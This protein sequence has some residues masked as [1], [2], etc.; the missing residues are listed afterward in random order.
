MFKTTRRSA[1]ALAAIAALAL[2]L[3]AAAKTTL[4][5]AHS[6]AKDHPVDKAMENFAALVKERS[7]GEVEVRVFAAG[8]LG[9]QREL[10]EQL[11]SGAL[12]FAHTNAAPLAAFEPT[13]GIF[14]LPYLFRDDAH[15]F[16]VTDGEIGRE[17]LDSAAA[18]GLV[19]LS[20]YDNGTRSFYA[21]KPVPTPKDLAGLKIRVQP[22]PVATRMVN[23]LGATA[24]PLA[25]GELYTAL[26]SKVVDGAE[27]NVTAL[28]LAKH[29]EVSKVYTRDEHTRVP[30]VLLISEMTM[31]RLPAAQQDIIRQAAVDSGKAHNEAWKAELRKAEGDAVAMG[32]TFVDADKAAYRAAVQPMYDDLKATP[33]LASLAERIQAL[34]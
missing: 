21:N 24:T 25:W 28:T 16:K 8:Q 32:V 34:K 2:P 15:F 23:L 7:N 31:S 20:Y 13:F 9:Q 29:G 12:D 22:G 26:Q 18:K 3:P 10:I 17:I 5:L 30:D 4:R 11:Q 19:G 1:I 33:A 27:N 14:D 6:L